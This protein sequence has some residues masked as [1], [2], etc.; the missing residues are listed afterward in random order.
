MTKGVFDWDAAAFFERL[1]R[2]NKLAVESG[3]VFCR[4]SGLEAF[5]DALLNMQSAQ[6]LVCANILGAGYTVLSPSP[7]TRRTKTIF[8]AMRHRLND[9]QARQQ[10]MDTLREIF[11]QFLSVLELER[12]RLEENCLYLQE[13]IQFTEISE[14]FFTGA[15]CAY[16]NLSVDTR[17][18]LV[19]NPDEWLEAPLP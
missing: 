13:R 3:A 15:A 2:S 4:V 12:T 7:V 11:R 16:F 18:D 9:M 6:T 14:Y 17:T 19:Y 8:L 1:S 10:A 5:E